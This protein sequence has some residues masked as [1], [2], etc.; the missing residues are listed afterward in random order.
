MAVYVRA[1]TNNLHNLTGGGIGQEKDNKLVMKISHHVLLIPPPPP[2][3][4]FR[5]DQIP[6]LTAINR[7]KQT[8]KL[9]NQFS[10]LQNSFI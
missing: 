3:M 5:K 1:S 4:A 8:K 9:T 7:R 6:V 2:S 10:I